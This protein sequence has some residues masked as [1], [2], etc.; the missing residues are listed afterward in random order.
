M[1]LVR[2]VLYQAP[3]GARIGDADLTYDGSELLVVQRYPDGRRELAFPK[4]GRRLALPDGVDYC[5]AMPGGRVL[6]VGI[7]SNRQNGRIFNR[8]GNEERVFDL[9]APVCDALVDWEDGDFWVSY[10]RLGVAVGLAGEGLVRFNARGEATVRFRSEF[11]GPESAGDTH[12]FCL[13]RGSTIWMMPDPDYYLLELDWARW[14]IRS[15]RVSWEAH[16]ADAINARPG[17]VYMAGSRQHGHVVHA[18]HLR[19]DLLEKVG[20]VRGRPRPVIT[21]NGVFLDILPHEVAFLALEGG[22]P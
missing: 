12:P 10:F 5:R 21:R 18:Y 9:D 8:D 20:E 19:E 14:S 1:S 16:G 6:A 3:A 22:K 17:V 7:R 4:S 11:S 13:G 2:T 15:R